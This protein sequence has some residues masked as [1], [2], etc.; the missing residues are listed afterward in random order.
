VVITPVVAEGLPGEIKAACTT[1]AT[2]VAFS[3]A[4]VRLLGATQQARD[5]IVARSSLDGLSWQRRL[6]PMR[7]LLEEAAGR[8][9]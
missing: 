6:A 8:I 1:A 3:E 4:V 5:E 2:E 7:G 9:S